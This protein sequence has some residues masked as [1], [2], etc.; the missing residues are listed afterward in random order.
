MNT[1]FLQPDDSAELD[2]DAGTGIRAETLPALGGF[3][4]HQCLDEKREPGD[5]NVL[6]SHTVIQNVLRH[7]KQDTTREHGG[8]LLG[9]E[10][11]LGSGDV[12]TVLVLHSLP[13]KNTVG[14]KT[15][16]TFGDA[17]WEEFDNYRRKLDALGLHLQRVGWYHSHPDIKIFL[18]PYDLDVN[19][20]FDGRKNP[21]ALVID[22][23]NH[24]AG[25]FVRGKVGYRPYSPQGYWEFRSPGESP[26]EWDNMRIAA[27][28]VS[29]ANAP[30]QTPPSAP[31]QSDDLASPPDVEP[32]EK[33]AAPAITRQKRSSSSQ[34]WRWRKDWLVFI[35]LLALLAAIDGVTSFYLKDTREQL[36]A[37]ENQVRKLQPAV[38]TPATNGN[39]QPATANESIQAPGT[40]SNSQATSTNP[41]N[42]APAK[43]IKS[44]AA[45]G[46]TSKATGNTKNKGSQ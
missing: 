44:P 34:V 28:G 43:N 35:G 31:S 8:L 39:S 4:L 45:A 41:S 42:V 26:D 37:L 32:D 6:C 1:K 38:N 13:A 11:A 14:S 22:P 46:S 10:T 9:Y 16:V 5:P 30:E 20:T 40:R 25:F 15:H 12:P 24:R 21:I 29:A 27:T 23:I 3:T 36:S 17:T 2:T 19:K 7:L 33:A 18:S